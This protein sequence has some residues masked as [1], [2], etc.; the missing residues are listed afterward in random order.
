MTD[1]HI[2]MNVDDSDDIHAMLINNAP[3]IVSGDQQH[4]YGGY[5]GRVVIDL[6]NDDSSETT[7]TRSR[8]S[9][10]LQKSAKF[11]AGNR[12]SEDNA[13]LA[14]QK[15]A[16]NF[17][18]NT[19]IFNQILKVR[20]DIDSLRRDIRR[21]KEMIQ[22]IG[23][24]GLA[25]QDKTLASHGTHRGAKMVLDGSGTEAETR[26]PC[27]ADPRPRQRGAAEL[28]SFL[29]DHG[30][31]DTEIRPRQVFPDYTPKYGTDNVT[32]KPA[33]IFI[34]RTASAVDP[35]IRSRLRANAKAPALVEEQLATNVAKKSN[36]SEK[37]T[38]LSPKAAT[39]QDLLSQDSIIRIDHKKQPLKILP[40]KAGSGNNPVTGNSSN[41]LVKLSSAV[42][43]TN[44]HGGPSKFL[45]NQAVLDYTD[46]IAASEEKKQWKTVQRQVPTTAKPDFFATAPSLSSENEVP[47][48]SVTQAFQT[49]SSTRYTARSRINYGRQMRK[50]IVFT[51][52][53]TPRALHSSTI[54]FIQFHD[55]A[56][57]QSTGPS[58]VPIV[59]SKSVF[60]EVDAPG[61]MDPFNSTL[62]ILGFA[63]LTSPK[64]PRD[65]ALK[66]VSPT[67]SSRK[68][69]I[70]PATTIGTRT[71]T[72]TTTT[73]ATSTTTTS[74]TTTPTTSRPTTTT[75]D[76]AA[77]NFATESTIE[78]PLIPAN[79][80]FLS[81]NFDGPFMPWFN[82][83]QLW[84]EGLFQR[85]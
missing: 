2:Q 9:H 73:T 62:V 26:L 53:P 54:P 42:R 8:M 43:I 21:V 78:V 64:A 35:T 10:R 44:N 69:V 12:I 85:G 59:P 70:T 25:R 81:N 32:A 3:G 60:S 84:P 58:V 82:D 83:P 17:R 46:K 61:D 80:N 66:T 36:N 33:Y 6:T 13:F 24:T 5:A 7:K 34:S 45:Q 29:Q 11:P 56:Q 22:Q 65:R 49:F 14:S 52:T 67:V 50:L 39:E 40:V 63:S 4:P 38:K 23:A 76:I 20:K 1:V 19:E 15:R 75:A 74:T 68:T 30:T 51:T 16:R 55:N 72:T 31:K 28:Q 79:L 47:G 57:T 48:M 77:E 18:S 41:D 37:S 71:R 27:S